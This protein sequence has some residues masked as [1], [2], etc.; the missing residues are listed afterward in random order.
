MKIALLCV[1]LCFLCT[2]VFA[3]TR[4][5]WRMVWNDEFSGN[6]IDTTKWDHE[7]DC[8]GGGNGELQC[9]TSR[10]QNSYVSN[11]N[12]YLV[13]KPERYT[14]SMNGCTN[15]N[16]NS[17][18]NTKDYTSARLRT[19]MS[20]TGS[21]KY[22]RF[23]FRAK[24]PKGKHLWPAM[25][26]LPTDY[27]YGNWAASGE[28]DIVESRGQEPF[29]TSSTLHYGG[30]WP[31]NRYTSTGKV[32]F[33]FDLT[34]DFH[35]YAL[36]WEE[37]EI[38][39][40]VDDI[41]MSTFDLDRNWYS[42]VGP[43]PYTKNLQPWDQ[44]FHILLNIAIGG[45]FFPANEYGTLSLQ[46]AQN[47][48]NPTMAIDYVRVF[49][50][51]TTPASSGAGGSSTSSSSSSGSGCNCG[52]TSSSGSGGASCLNHNAL[53]DGQ[54]QLA[55]KQNGQQTNTVA[56]LGFG[57]TLSNFIVGSVIAG[58][59]LLAVSAGLI[60]FV[61]VRAVRWMRANTPEPRE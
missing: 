17:C 16:D 12:L 6:S 54:F 8:W 32:T 20:P 13:A 41:L 46:E 45:G 44:K 26:M 27:V 10:P 25:W 34:A 11:G 3:Q 2:A 48:Q 57:T 18:G 40:Y 29:I 42:G 43:N 35:V 14:G 15:N 55:N 24:L 33:P 52:T 30:V 53:E 5:G 61:V 36:E 28:I 23:E 22:G 37:K 59:T 47:W 9:Y 50:R 38:R 1:V 31:N 58:L 4:P 19:K 39:T 7:V 60:A 56:V 51:D 49:T 21:W